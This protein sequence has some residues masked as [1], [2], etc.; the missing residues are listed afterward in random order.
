M[1]SGQ[2]TE[3]PV[4]L[5]SCDFEL[6]ALRG[7]CSRRHCHG[8]NIK[9]NIKNLSLALREQASEDFDG[10]GAAEAG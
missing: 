5:G 1:V 4:K 2:T 6:W 10:F 9:K 7:L 3:P 8:Q